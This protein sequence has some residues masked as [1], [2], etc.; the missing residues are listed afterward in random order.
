MPSASS[1]ISGSVNYRVHRCARGR[2]ECC[3]AHEHQRALE[4]D[5]ILPKNQGGSDAISNLQALCIADAYPVS[6]GHSLVIPRR[7]G[8]VGLEL[9]QPEWNAVVELVH[10][11]QRW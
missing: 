4:V 7:H 10:S 9:H 5:H 11:I 1:P 3:G 6:E 2:C 8:A